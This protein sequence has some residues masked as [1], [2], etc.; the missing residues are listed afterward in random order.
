MPSVPGLLISLKLTSALMLGHV[1]GL[2][3]EHQRPDAHASKYVTVN[4]ENILGYD[5]VKE[6]LEKDP[7]H[8]PQ[9]PAHL[10]GDEKMQKM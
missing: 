9:L 3:H 10:N 1:I 4:I 2:H 6:R 8:D 5:K 7:I